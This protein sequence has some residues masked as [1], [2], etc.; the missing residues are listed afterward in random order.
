MIDEAQRSIRPGGWHFPWN[1]WF[2]MVWSNM[3]VK[4]LGN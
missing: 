3:A 4:Q 1:R 2:I